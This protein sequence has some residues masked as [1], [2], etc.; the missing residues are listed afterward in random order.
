MAGILGQLLILIAFVATG[1]AGFAFYRA[2][3]YPDDPFDWKRTGRILWS[4]MTGSVFAAWAILIV[5]I[6]TH[7]F[8]YAYVWGHSSRD[9]PMYYLFSASWEGQEGS[10]LL[11]IILNSAVGLTLIK[12]AARSYEAPVMAVVAFCQVFLLS[13]I[14]GLK[15]GPLEIGATPFE[16][17]A[18]ANPDVPV[19]Q[20]DPN[21]VPADGSGLND[22]L[23]NYWMVIH[24][25][26]L[27][28][29]FATMIVPFAF[30]V[31]A[32]WKERYTEWVRPA[33]PWTL[34]SVMCLGV[35][36]AMGGY[37]AYETLSFGGFWAWDPVENSSFVPW[38]IG[39]AAIHMMLIQ[40]KSGI[41]HK[42]ALFLNILAYMLV[43]YSTFLTRSGILGD[44]SV[45]SFVDLGLYNQLLIWILAM[46]IVGFGLFAYRYKSLPKPSKEPPF[47]SREFMI[48]SGAVLLCV[49]G[50]VVIL[51][52]SSPIFGKFFR[53]NPATV[54]IEFYNDWTL[55]L[56]VGFVFLAGLGQLFWWNKMSVENINRVLLAPIAL[57]VV[58]TVL[59]LVLTPFVENSITPGP[60]GFWDTYGTGMLLLLLL[61]VAFFAFYGNG[62]VLWRVS[63]GNPKL[64]G[65]AL[66]HVGLGIAVLGIISSAGFNNPLSNA[67]PGSD[68]ENFVL[69]RGAP[70]N[71]EG[72]RVEYV[73]T[74]PGERGQT[75]FVLNFT[76]PRGNDFTMKPIAYQSNSG[77]WIQHPDL[78]LYVEKDIF[79]AVTP[80]AMVDQDTNTNGN[81]L[82]LARGD[83]RALGNNDFSIRFEAFETNLD[84]EA[85]MNETEVNQTEIAV[86]AVLTVTNLKTN[87]SRALRPLYIIRKDRSVNTV[88]DGVEEWDLSVLFTGM[89]V[90]TGE[91]SL[92]MDGV[93]T[94]AQDW[95]VVQ[96]YEKPVISL[97]WIGL[98]LLTFGFVLS[99]IRRMHD[100]KLSM[101]R[102]AV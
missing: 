51:G 37:W 12:W 47:L 66:A 45:H 99:I 24:P 60:G 8:Q 71:V 14:V 73:G 32:L 41:G 101:K 50:A 84:L 48:F 53:D 20:A 25:P 74:E 62:L 98:I 88:A 22:L 56:A 96:A 79:V 38:I 27:F 68:R 81:E 13:M 54:P 92:V 85:H 7:Q 93:E 31:S 70:M 86:G 18:E 36:I 6:A 44:V 65:G 94:A 59:I 21:F 39:V 102:G 83:M 58:S 97:V 10:F 69:E 100:V 61:F 87:E 29:G 43:I 63:R 46:G 34:A 15:F 72:Y 9:L 82:T 76:D 77:Q 57:A 55:P 80:R 35:G 52:T 26:M 2:A 1:L 17:I 67:P 49:V 11:W 91:I 30:A 40:R 4:V 28:V 90:N 16:T 42:A 78:K 5:L 23:Q 64:A 33:L 95:I 75:E 89:N 19:F 3:Q